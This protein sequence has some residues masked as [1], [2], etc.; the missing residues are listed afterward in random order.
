MEPKITFSTL[1]KKCKE[2]NARS[3]KYF[4]PSPEFLKLELLIKTGLKWRSKARKMTRIRRV[5]RLV[6]VGS[7]G[8]ALAAVAG[9]ELAPATAPKL[10]RIM[11]QIV[12]SGR[13]LAHTRG[14]SLTQ[15]RLMAFQDGGL[16]PIPFQIDER[17]PAGS[18]LMT[19]PDGSIDPGNGALDDQDELVFMVRD[20]G[21]AGDPGAGGIGAAAWDR[22]QVKDPQS[23]AGGWIYLVAF[24][25][26]PPPLSPK[27]YMQYVEK[28]DHD[29]LITPYY[30]LHFPKGDVFFRELMISPAAGGN[31]ENFL[32]RIKMRS[33]VELLGGVFAVGKT[34]ENFV[35]RVLGV[36]AGPV[37]V[38]RQTDTRLKLLLSLQSPAAIVNGCFYPCGFEFP[39]LL[40]LPFRMDLIA[41]DAYFRQGWDLNRQA[42]G[43]KFYSN[44]N[45]EAV[46]LDGTMSPEEISLAADPN[47]LQWA[48]GTGA[49]GTFL[50]FG[51]WSSSAPLKARLYYEDNLSRREPPESEPGVMGFAYRLENLLKMGGKAYP[52]NIVNY[53]VPDFGGDIERALR[54]L[55]DPLVVEVEGRKIAG[56]AGAE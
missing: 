50:F 48:L 41:S 46:T 56:P 54:V 53:V 38:I 11:D 20:A 23:G 34:E 55:K 3:E 25:K 32:D 21:A 42:L 40:S 37:R 6:M 29:E 26:D 30:T 14:S 5:F 10:D 9:S 35:T 52:F 28:A 33:E 31:G 15:L 22:V 27:S 36:R 7:L 47:T 43:L 13:E 12:I 45:R 16:E 44:L 51:V 4:F 39:S 19:R 2:K 1:E 17:T 24:G 18:Y 49:V 8:P